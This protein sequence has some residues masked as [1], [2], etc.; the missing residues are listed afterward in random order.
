VHGPPTRRAPLFRAAR[1]GACC[2]QCRAGEL[3][4]CRPFPAAPRAARSWDVANRTGLSGDAAS[5]QEYLVKLPN[6]IRR[7]AEK[8]AGEL[9]GGRAVG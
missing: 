6:R 5:A 1:K 3:T 4:R 2:A 9:L 8:A 7:L